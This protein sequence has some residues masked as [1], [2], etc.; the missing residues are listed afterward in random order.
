MK[1]FN[2]CFVY[3][4]RCSDQSLYTGWTKDLKRRL[5][6]HNEGIKGAKY[7]RSRRPV[8]LVYEKEYTNAVTAQAEERRIKRM[9]RQE[10]LFFLTNPK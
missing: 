10:K 1:N 6:E 3:I 4:V 7:T 2:R 5:A 9:P 8:T